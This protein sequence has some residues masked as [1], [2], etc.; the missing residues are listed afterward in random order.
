MIYTFER[1]EGFYPLELDNDLSAIENAKLNPGTVRVTNEETGVIVW[2][3]ED[4][5]VKI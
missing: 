1:K 2:T 3:K 4:E 5:A